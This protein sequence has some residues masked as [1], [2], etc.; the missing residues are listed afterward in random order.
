MKILGVSG[1]VGHDPSAALVVDGRTVACAEE[2]RFVRVKHAKDIQPA[3]SVRYCLAAGGVDPRDVD[4]VAYPFVRVG[5][6]DRGRWHYARRHL[7]S[8]DRAFKAVFNPNR[9]YR[10]N[11]RNV[12]RM[13]AEIGI[14]LSRTRLVTVPHHLAHASSA[15]HLS[16]FEEAAILSVDGVGEYATTWLG[17]GRSGR[18][19]RIREFYAPDSLGG[20]YGAMTEYLGFEMLD[21]EF[22]VMGM[23][24]YGDPSRADIS[25]LLRYGPEGFELDTR[26]VNCLGVRR[27]H[28]EDGRGRFFS[29]SLPELLGASPRVGDEIDEPY[30]HIAA[31][32]Q[33]ALE[34]AVL[35]LVRRFLGPAIERT[36]RLCLAGGVAL[37]VKMNQRLLAESGARELYVQPAAGDAGTSLGAATYL[38]WQNGE[39]LEPMRHVYLG[40][41]YSDE[42]IEVAL[43]KR[44]HSFRRED[45]I[46]AS[47]ARLLADGKVVAWF[48][49]RMEFG[50][51]ALGNRSILANPAI[52]GVANEVNARIKYRERWRPFCPSLLDDAAREI[53]GSDHPAPFMVLS[54]AVTP[55]W[56]FRI[57]EVVHVDGTVRPQV[58]SR[59][60]NPRYHELLTRFRELTGVP[61]LLNTSLNRR[62]EPMVMSP[63]HA[64]DMFEGSGL[65]V[66]A[67]GD[68]LVTKSAP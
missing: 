9:R 35:G 4:A 19:E 14:D 13:L 51:R 41:E 40:P 63:D 60:T 21:G 15:Y 39:R 33:K 12:T 31:A 22:K 50:P 3:L 8:P 42:E 55:E 10:K 45:S 2:E 27:W 25:Q 5:F 54:F 67:M 49:G 62:G 24:P 6:L 65:E 30:V 1:A 47:I 56:R 38:A 37:N 59:D 23:A 61:V 26:F 64:L 32:V 44:S 57:P 53:L 66:L 7:Y 48:Q 17:E 68:Y 29:K 18:L 58:V 28:D 36:G 52:P 20:F 46:T 11:L 16:G 34:E 43:A